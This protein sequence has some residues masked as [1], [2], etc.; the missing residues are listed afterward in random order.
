MMASVSHRE[1][2]ALPAGLAALHALAVPYTAA[3]VP[4]GADRELLALC[5][6]F[7]SVERRM[8]RLLAAAQAAR[9][10]GDV[11]RASHLSGVQGRR[12]HYSQALMAEVMN[13]AATTPGGLCAK[14]EVLATT[15]QYEW[16]GGPAWES[17]GVWSLCRDLLGHEPTENGTGGVL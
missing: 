8:N 3:S 6:R 16:S 12:L 7:M 9:E 5:R 14:A 15:I 2:I 10:A 13:L 11:D 1:A 4:Q 17:L